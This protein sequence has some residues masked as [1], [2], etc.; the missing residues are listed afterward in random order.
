MW[1]KKKVY[2]GLVPHIFDQAT[3]I[4]VAVEYWLMYK[5]NENVGDLNPFHYFV[6]TI[7]FLF[8]HRLV[9]TLTLYYLTRNPFDA[10]LQSFDLLL[11]KAIW[12]NYKLGS[13]EPSNIQR[14]LGI[15]VCFYLLFNNYIMC[16]KTT[17]R[18][19]HSN[20]HHKLLCQLFLL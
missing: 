3:D 20:H 5:N 2:W 12:T 9:S 7:L 18:K 1:S 19:Q 10:L 14:Y 16:I 4:S 6:G 8:L 13:N 11:V 17:K 15:L